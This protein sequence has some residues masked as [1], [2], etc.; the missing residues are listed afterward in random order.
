MNISPRPVH[1]VEVSNMN[2]SPRPVH[3]VEV[4][5]MNI[6]PRPDQWGGGE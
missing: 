6:S 5:N 4:S 1:G 2:I 3:G